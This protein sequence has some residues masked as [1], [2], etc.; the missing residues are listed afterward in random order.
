MSRLRTRGISGQG[1]TQKFRHSHFSTPIIK[2]NVL[3]M[4]INSH[5]LDVN[6]IVHPFYLCL[7]RDEL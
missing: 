3:K 2:R 5:K 6:L 7:P 1:M 4:L